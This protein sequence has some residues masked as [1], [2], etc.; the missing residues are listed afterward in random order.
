MLM[1]G[2]KAEIQLLEDSGDLTQWL[3]NNLT[4]LLSP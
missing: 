2:I 1:M 4:R 3:E